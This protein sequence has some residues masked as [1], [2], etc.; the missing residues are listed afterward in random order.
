VLSRASAAAIPQ[1]TLPNRNYIV[2]AYDLE[3]T[4][5]IS[6]VQPADQEMVTVTGSGAD[7]ASNLISHVH[8]GDLSTIDLLVMCSCSTK[9]RAILAIGKQKAEGEAAE[10][11]VGK[12][13]GGRG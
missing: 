2:Q 13:R 9:G 4:G 3:S 8:S 10:E 6:V 11:E 7:P 12:G 5:E 1:L